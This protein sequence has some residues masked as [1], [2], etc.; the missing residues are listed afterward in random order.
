MVNGGGDVL[1]TT[2]PDDQPWRI[3]IRDAHQPQRL[4]AVLPLQA[5]VVASSGDYERFHD[6]DGRRYHHIMDPATGLSTQ[7][8]NGLTMVMPT[9]N[10][11]NGLGTAAMVAGPEHAMQRLQQWGVPQAVLMHADGRVQAS[12]ALLRQLQPAPGQ[13]SIRGLNA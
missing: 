4:L 11:L 12:A 9:A 1:V 10:L 13:T 5:G 7:G 3:G 2:R 8:V 6:V